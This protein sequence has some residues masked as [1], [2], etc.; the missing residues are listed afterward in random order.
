MTRRLQAVTV[1][2]DVED[3]PPD[4]AARPVDETPRQTADR[5]SD[6]LRRAADHLA[7]RPD[8]RGVIFPRI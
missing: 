1:H 3:D 4:S 2:F 8:F 7:L 6:A 5:Y